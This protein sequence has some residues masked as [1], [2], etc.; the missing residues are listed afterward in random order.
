MGDGYRKIPTDRGP[1]PR[2]PELEPGKIQ[3]MDP[4][5]PLLHQAAVA[6]MASLVRDKDNEGCFDPDAIARDAYRCAKALVDEIQAQ[7][8]PDFNVKE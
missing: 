3:I 1:A 8:D 5:P 2:P 6:A 4:W 7:E